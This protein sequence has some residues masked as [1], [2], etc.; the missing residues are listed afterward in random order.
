VSV[1]YGD[2]AKDG[3]GDDPAAQPTSDE[4]YARQALALGMLL[5]LPGIPT[6][7]YGDEVGLAGGRD[8]DSRRVLPDALSR[9]QT[10]LL[11]QTRRLAMLRRCLP[12]LRRG[13]RVPLVVADAVYAFARDAGDGAPAVILV[14]AATNERELAVPA[15]SPQGAFVDALTGDAIAIGPQGTSVPMRPL[16][17][18]VLVPE[19]HACVL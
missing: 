10:R 14:S 17:L 3:W 15:S 9:P 1:A 11:D 6:I 18:R 12:A 13:A 5:T 19:G 7:Y 8:P 4:P 16:S 2:D